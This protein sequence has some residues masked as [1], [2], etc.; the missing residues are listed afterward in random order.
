VNEITITFTENEARALVPWK[1]SDH[2]AAEWNRRQ[3]CAEDAISK[4]RSALREQGAP[5]TD[6]HQSSL[7]DLAA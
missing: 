1:G 7:G 6:P 4:I 3:D 2:T 5:E